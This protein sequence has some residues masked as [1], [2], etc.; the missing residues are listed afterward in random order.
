[1]LQHPREFQAQVAGV[2]TTPTGY[3]QWHRSLAAELAR[4]ASRDPRR[5][6]NDPIVYGYVS[7][8]PPSW[9]DPYGLER[10]TVPPPD[11]NKA[12]VSRLGV[13]VM[14]DY[15]CAVDC[16]KSVDTRPNW[17]GTCYFGVPITERQVTCVCGTPTSSCNLVA[18]SGTDDDC[19]LT[20]SLGS[21]YLVTYEWSWVEPGC[22]TSLRFSIVFEGTVQPWPSIEDVWNEFKNRWPK[23][24]KAEEIWERI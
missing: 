5:Y 7:S 6:S 13:P 8:S 10:V 1:L 2:P 16:V 21:M 18:S 11:K 24:R 22:P 9:G 12:R 23:L 4:F 17:L 20:Y 15:E 14:C 19:P 3:H